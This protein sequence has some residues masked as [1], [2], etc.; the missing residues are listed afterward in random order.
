MERFLKKTK[1]SPSCHY[2]TT[3]LTASVLVSKQSENMLE[4]LKLSNGRE[5]A[6]DGELGEER[7]VDGWEEQII[8]DSCGWFP[9]VKSVVGPRHP[10]RKDP[11]LDYDVDSDEEWEEEDLGES[12]S[13]CDKDDEEN[14][15]EEGCAKAED[16]E[17]SE[18]G[19]FVLIDISQKMRA[20]NMTGWKLMMLMRSKAHLALS[21]I[22]RAKNFVVCLSNKS[23][24]TT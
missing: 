11:N 5:F 10:F 17:D 16:D 23:I 12:L 13:D 18:D 3:E 9:H 1:P 22:W 14:L 7:L 2:P 6:N 20:W 4:E 15:E 21:K 8:D 24:S 19:F